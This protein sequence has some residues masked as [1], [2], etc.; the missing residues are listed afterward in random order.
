MKLL[1]ELCFFVIAAVPCMSTSAVI[2][3]AHFAQKLARHLTTTHGK[4]LLHIYCELGFIPETHAFIANL[5]RSGGKVDYAISNVKYALNERCSQGNTPLHYACM[6]GHK[7]LVSY[8]LGQGAAFDIVNN[9]GKTAV[10]IATELPESTTR[11][12]LL[13][14]FEEYSRQRKSP[15]P[16]VVGC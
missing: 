5:Y 4:S 14:I 2:C 7:G 13:E 8:L 6:R 1:K 15:R 9:E 10:Q 11:T 16:P 3:T 12:T